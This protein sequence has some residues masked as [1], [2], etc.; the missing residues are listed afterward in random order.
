MTALLAALLL[1]QAAAVDASQSSAARASSPTGGGTAPACTYTS[2]GTGAVTRTC[3]QKMSDWL[4]ASD[5]GTIQQAIT[6]AGTTG[7]VLIPASYGAGTFTNPNNILVLDLRS[8]T[9]GIT[10]AVSVSNTATAIT[11]NASGNGGHG[12]SATG[13]PSSSSYGVLAFGGSPSGIA[14]WAQ[15][16]STNGV[17]ISVGSG[18][19]IL[20]GSETF[21]T[22]NANPN[23]SN[24]QIVGCSDCTVSNPCAAGGLGALAKRLNNVWVCN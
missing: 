19:L 14:I 15:P 23:S 2:S 7:A 4:S 16:G 17:A 6:Q 10:G 5:F 22:L 12:I 24:F 11:A 21:A 18:G 13:G 8:A 1:A 9:L 20:L 3:T